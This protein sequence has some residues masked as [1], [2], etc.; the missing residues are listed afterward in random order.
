MMKNNLKGAKH[1]DLHQKNVKTSIALLIFYDLMILRQKESERSPESY[2]FSAF[3]ISEPLVMYENG[4]N[5]YSNT[6]HLPPLWDDVQT[7]PHKEHRH[8]MFSSE[9]KK[10]AG[11]KKPQTKT[12]FSPENTLC[13]HEFEGD[14]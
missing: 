5:I 3:V 11:R 14:L 4:N 1:Q 10:A 13:N 6:H 2:N 12:M 9:C 7:K 8:L